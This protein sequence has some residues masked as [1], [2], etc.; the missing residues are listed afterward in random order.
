MLFHVL[1][2]HLKLVIFSTFVENLHPVVRRKGSQTVGE[3]KPTACITPGKP[4]PGAHWQG[5][6]NKLARRKK[7][8]PN[9]PH[10]VI[11]QLRDQN[12]T[13]RTEQH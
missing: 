2:V 8:T 7:Q 5:R 1:H 10:T 12:K 11:V 4:S 13:I 6:R 3:K 9:K